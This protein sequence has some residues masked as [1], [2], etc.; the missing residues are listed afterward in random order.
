ML[1]MSL[2]Y[3]HSLPAIE[4]MGGCLAQH[5]SARAVILNLWTDSLEYKLRNQAGAFLQGQNDDHLWT[6]IEFWKDDYAPLVEY[7]ESLLGIKCE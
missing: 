4:L 5:K 3:S 7:I 1:K 6:L 2:K